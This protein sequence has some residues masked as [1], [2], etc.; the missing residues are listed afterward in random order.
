MK[1]LLIQINIGI[2][3]DGDGQIIKDI[4]KLINLYLNNESVYLVGGIR[5]KEDSL[6]NLFKNCK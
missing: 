3:M 1:G 2:A 6:L 5:Q 4:S